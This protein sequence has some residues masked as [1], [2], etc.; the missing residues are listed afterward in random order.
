MRVYLAETVYGARVPPLRL[1]GGVLDLQAGLDVLH[2]GGDEAD[3]CAG[4][5]A[6]YSMA[7]RREI[8]RRGAGVAEEG[9]EP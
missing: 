6:C 4:E 2:G 3:G 7:Q 5:D 8:G 1:I 9:L